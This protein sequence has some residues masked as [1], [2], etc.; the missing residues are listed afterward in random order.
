MRWCNASNPG[1]LWSHRYSSLHR[2]SH[3]YTQL[4]TGLLETQ[5]LWK[6]RDVLTERTRTGR[7]TDRYVLRS[8]IHHRL[9]SINEMIV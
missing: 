3:C 4:C 6:R 9:I 7:K 8:H 1:E 2:L 5:S